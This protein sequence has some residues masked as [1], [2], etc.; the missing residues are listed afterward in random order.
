[1]RGASWRQT[2]RTRRREIRKLLRQSPS[3]GRQVPTMMVDAYLD[4]VED[5]VDVAGL[6]SAK[7]P[8]DC[9]YAPDDVLAEDHFPHESF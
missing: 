1:L 4:S 5:A 6:P 3:L 8:A 9:P 2:F 7:F